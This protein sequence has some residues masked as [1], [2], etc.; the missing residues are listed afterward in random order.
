M[1]NPLALALPPPQV[2]SLLANEDI[3]LLRSIF[4]LFYDTALRGSLVFDV[5]SECLFQFITIHHNCPR[6]E[7]SY[8]KR[9][10][11]KHKRDYKT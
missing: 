1:L 10:E 3:N 2:P 11:T 5:G 7:C 9:E 4:E 8:Y 6:E